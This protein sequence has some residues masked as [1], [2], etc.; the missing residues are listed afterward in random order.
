[1]HKGI[2][3]LL[4][5]IL[6]SCE[7]KL[8]DS[9]GKFNDLVIISSLEDRSILEEIID[10]NIFMDTIFTPEPE[11]LLNKIWI[12]PE[13]FKFYKNYSNLV[14]ISISDPI[15]QTIDLLIDQFSKNHQIKSF[16]VILNDVY[17]SNQSIIIIKENNQSLFKNT[18]DSTLVY[19]N[20]AIKKHIN[21]LYYKR[22]KNF[23]SDTVIAN[24][25]HKLF[26][27]SFYFRDDFKI[28]A[29]EESNNLKYLW[30]G[31][32]DIYSENSN[33]QWFIIKDLIGSVSE[34]NINLLNLI[35]SNINEIIDDIEVVSKY[36]KFSIKETNDYKIYKFNGLYNHYGYKTG[37]PLV[38][39]ILKDKNDKKNKIIFGMVNAP[40]QSKL[41]SI[42]ELE[43]IVINSIF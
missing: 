22:Y 12:K 14:F 28:I 6:I 2:I 17:S 40:G 11:P 25:V 16:P 4:I 13:Q 21:H 35:D 18:L 20:S 30:L 29:Q 19:I 42:K 24:L 39:F 37:G 41:N 3:F 36:S 10:N 27:Q 38:S 7:S 34:D 31:R 43:S 15:D 26:N 1:M 33:Y 8:D 5:L 9:K 23:K 32:G